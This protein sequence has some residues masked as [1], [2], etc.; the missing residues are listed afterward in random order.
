[1]LNFALEILCHKFF[2][3]VRFLKKKKPFA[4]Y[5]NGCNAIIPVRKYQ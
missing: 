3:A 1:M 5:A 2:I 4:I